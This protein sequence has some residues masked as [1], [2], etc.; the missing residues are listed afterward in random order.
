MKKTGKLLL[1]FMLM[2]SFIL[3][4]MGIVTSV[5]AADEPYTVTYPYSFEGDITVTLNENEEFEYAK[6]YRTTYNQ[7]E[8]TGKLTLK[9][10]NEFV[11]SYE[12]GD[13]PEVS[14]ENN[15]ERAVLTYNIANYDDITGYVKIEFKKKGDPKVY[16]VEWNRPEPSVFKPSILETTATAVEK[17][18]YY[19]ITLKCDTG[20]KNEKCDIVCVYVYDENNNKIDEV[21]TSEFEYFDFDEDGNELVTYSCLL[22]GHKYK[23]IVEN[24]YGVLSDAFEVTDIENVDVPDELKEAK[25]VPDTSTKSS[26]SLKVSKKNNGSK[27]NLTATTNKKCTIFVDGVYEGKTKSNKLKFE[28]LENGTY[29][30][31]AVDSKGAFTEK[32]VKI[33]GLKN[34]RSKAPKITSREDWNDASENNSKLPQT[35]TIAVGTVILLAVI[36]AVVGLIVYKKKGVKA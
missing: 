7:D 25:D 2:L 13:F 33:T 5:E 17:P 15:V 20:N 23:F 16:I 35:G 11:D 1:S 4:G 32:K 31:R 27:A 19:N 34:D 12:E 8:E 3:S 24:S 6:V 22:G 14:A 18:G 29:T 30:I 28:I 26:I 21:S 9:N 10:E 36:L